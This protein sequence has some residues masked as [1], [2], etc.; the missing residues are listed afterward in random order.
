MPLGWRRSTSSQPD[1]APGCRR[2]QQNWSVQFLKSDCPVS[3]VSSK[4][5]RFLFVSCGNRQISFQ[6]SDAPQ[7]GNSLFLD[8]S[9]G[10]GQGS[11]D[12][13]QMQ[14]IDVEHQKNGVN[15]E[16]EHPVLPENEYIEGN[17]V[18]ALPAQ[19][20]IDEH[21]DGVDLLPNDLMQEIQGRYQ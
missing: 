13:A 21:D 19:H 16:L 18:L 8:G 14:S 12:I 6:P 10:N 20:L 2:S 11:T 9:V 3:I 5:F 15:A 1:S 17:L 4:G 7:G